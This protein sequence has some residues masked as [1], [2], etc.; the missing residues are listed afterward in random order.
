LGLII[1]VIIKREKFPQW[2][3]GIKNGQAAA[4]LARLSMREDERNKINMIEIKL[5]CGLNHHPESGRV[6]FLVISITPTSLPF[7]FYLCTFR[8]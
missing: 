6:L 1:I 2:D 3:V 8:N 5:R 4:C 7:L